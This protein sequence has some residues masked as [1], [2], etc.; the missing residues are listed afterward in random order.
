MMEEVNEFDF[1]NRI[2]SN[3]YDSIQDGDVENCLRPKTLDEYIGQEK[4]KSN[5]KVYI[6]SAK[7]R[8]E[9][10][11]H[12]L[13]YGPPGLGKT[14]LSAII[15]NEMGVNIRTTSGP[16]IEKAGDLAAILTNL[17]PGDVLFIDEIHR[18]SKVAEEIRNLEDKA[19]MYEDALGT[20]LVKL[21][22]K[23]MDEHDSR[24]ITKLLHIIGDYERIS[25]H[26]V[27][28]V[29]SAEEMRDK[30]L[31]F[32]PEARR[33]LSVLTAAVADILSITS[34]AFAAND[35]TRASDIEPLEQVVDE[36]RDRIR[37]HHIKR[38]QKSECTIEHGFVLADLLT[39]CE[40][41]ADHCSNIGGCVIEIS[42][43][44][45]LDMHKYLS[46][47]R[48]GS[49]DYEAKCAAYRAKYTL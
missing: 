7:L 8:S 28:I 45:A 34:E 24:Q 27:N 12:V 23:D 36:L 18:L 11:D 43:Y 3:E 15:A 25:D 49:S 48:D 39:N 6:E 19:D 30:K 47:L 21:S 42:A 44:D 9:A 17:G 46:D 14:T 37:R 38:L 16:A 1:E 31:T 41:V 26:A 13:L 10:L 40:R 29:E 22:A 32:S 5:L 33:E 35:L 4:A 2:V 20:Y